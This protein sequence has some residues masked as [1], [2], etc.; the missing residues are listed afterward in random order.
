MQNI[1]NNIGISETKRDLEFQYQKL[2]LHPMCKP[3]ESIC[4]K[5][6]EKNSWCWQ[7]TSIQE[8]HLFPMQ[9]NNIFGRNYFIL[10]FRLSVAPSQ[11]KSSQDSSNPA[12]AAPQSPGGVPRRHRQKAFLCTLY[13]YVSIL[14]WRI[15]NFPHTQ[16]RVARIV[17]HGNV[18]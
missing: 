18:S 16:D 7:Q 8:I 5:F 11:T 9:E 4:Q 15:H 3:F 6:W 13:L 14:D 2:H 10:I 1:P 12:G 17:P